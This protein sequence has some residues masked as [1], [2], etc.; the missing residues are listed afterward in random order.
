MSLWSTFMDSLWEWNLSTFSLP[1]GDREEKMRWRRQF[2]PSCASVY[3][4]QTLLFRQRIFC[5]LPLLFSLFECVSYFFFPSFS[6]FLCFFHS[7]ASVEMKERESWN[8]KLNKRR[9]EEKRL[10]GGRKEKWE[11]KCFYTPNNGYSLC[12]MK[13]GRERIDTKRNER[14]IERGRERIDTKENERKRMKGEE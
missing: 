13:R 7:A 6:S 4:K 14:R 9:W 10:K 3:R 1:H 8:E 5:F 2:S 12:R 11:E